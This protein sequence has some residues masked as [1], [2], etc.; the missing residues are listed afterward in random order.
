[1]VRAFGV[2]LVSIVAC[3]GQRPVEAPVEFTACR[4]ERARQT[5]R[6]T[7]VEAA[8]V[9]A[10]AR[11]VALEV[12]I[13]EQRNRAQARPAAPT[14]PARPP[15][16]GLD[17]DRVYP[18]SITGSPVRGSAEARVTV[19]AFFGYDCIYCARVDATLKRLGE[20]YGPD[21]RLIVKHNPLPQQPRSLPAAIASECGRDQDRF[22]PLHDLMIANHRRLGDAALASYAAQAGVEVAAWQACV[23]EQRPRPRIER[24][25]TLALD[26]GVRVGPTLFINGRSL[27]GALPA[28]VIQ[29][30]IDEEL[31][32]AEASGIA[33]AEYYERAVVKA[34]TER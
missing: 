20:T 26:L 15:H 30:S 13:S 22:W 12:E 8:L 28:A 25:R 18:V 4:D 2:V 16:H 27:A 5:Q 1:M 29:R 17:P 7:E 6:L 14:K 21:L 31:A 9:E 33:P 3:A 24:D 11:V 34:G 19:V 23:A 32:R 10:R